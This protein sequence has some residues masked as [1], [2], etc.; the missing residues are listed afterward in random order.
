MPE[1]HASSTVFSPTEIRRFQTDINGQRH[2]GAYEPGRWSVSPLNRDVDVVGQMPSSVRLRDVT[3][4]SLEALPGVVLTDD[5]KTSFLEM[6]V[7]SGLPEIVTAPV[8]SRG[9]EGARSDVAAIKS[10][11]PDCRVTSPAVFRLEDLRTAAEAGV[12]AVQVWMPPWGEASVI[13]EP[14]VY[15]ETWQGGDWRSLG[16]PTSRDGFLNRALDLVKAAKDDGLQVTVP[17]LMVSYLDDERH[18]QAVAAFVEAGADEIALFD[19]PG[20]MG[21]E[22]MGALVARTRALAPTVDIGLHPHNSF[23][24]ATAVAVSAARAGADVIEVSV[25]GYCGGP[26]NAD[27]ASTVA[28]FEAL[29]GVRTGVD[30]SVLQTLARVAESMTGY[31]RAYNH[32]VTGE[33]VFNWGGMDFMTQ[34]L[35]V[36]NLLHNCIAPEW[37]GSSPGLPVTEM[38]GPYTV[39]DKL[40][41]L[42][43]T[44]THDQVDHVHSAVKSQMR[45]LGRQLTD[46]EIAELA[47]AAGAAAT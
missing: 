37:V 7:R 43:F 2:P 32:P 16:L 15:A 47:R 38:S 14:I 34:E 24:M 6:L 17:L 19:G 26:G 10:L 18:E 12:D 41:E 22:A 42:G 21:P 20:A 39:R 30:P 35:A 46:Q 28:A 1:S 5:A 44:A 25:N 27:L 3:L 8:R 4:R 9:L 40:T 36:D 23:G 33:R 29:Y 11:S 13:Y 45:D 31:Q